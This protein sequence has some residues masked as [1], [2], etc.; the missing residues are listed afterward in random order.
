[1]KAGF[2]PV[3]S[4]KHGLKKASFFEGLQYPWVLLSMASVFR[5][6]W[7]GSYSGLA[8]V[9]MVLLFTLKKDEK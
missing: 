4:F 9:F 7:N 6:G 8:G 5:F 3:F 2:C 1:M